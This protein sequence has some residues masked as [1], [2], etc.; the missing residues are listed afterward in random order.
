M[1]DDRRELR[2]QPKQQA[3]WHEIE[4]GVSP[5]VGVGGARGGGKSHLIRSINLLRRWKYPGT[6]S[7]IFRRTFPEL[8]RNHVI[9]LFKEFPELRG[10]YNTQTKTLT[11]PNGSTTEFVTAD[12]DG[13][14][15]KLQGA[16][17]ADIFIDEATHMVQEDFEWLRTCLRSDSTSTI[18]PRM[19]VTC[20]PGGVGHAFIKRVFI[21]R[22]YHENERSEDYSFVPV[23][24]QDNVEWARE[25]LAEDGFSAKDYYGWED[26]RRLEYFIS[27]TA[28]GRNLNSLPTKMR[29]AHLYGRWDVFAGQFFDVFDV[30]RHVHGYREMGL[31]TFHPRWIGFDW[32]FDHP[33]SILWLAHNGQRYCVYREL[34]LR[35]TPARQLASMIAASTKGMGETIA[36]VYLSP[37]A[38]ARKQDEHTLALEIGDLLASEGLPRPTRA[39][40]DRIGGWNFIY[41][42]LSTDQLWITPECKDLIETIPRLIRDEDKPEDVLK[43]DGDDSAEALRYGLMSRVRQQGTKDIDRLIREKVTSADPTVAAFQARIAESKL[44]SS[45]QFSKGRRHRQV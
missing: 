29:D 45:L 17:Y 32:G 6:A 7:M 19:V 38:F 15:K 43:Q 2:L 26:G 13:R 3:V 30:E 5:L 37:D 10:L 25:S 27:R 11:F 8:Q 22:K 42:L 35:E 34:V 14:L 1:S 40:T 16:Q 33:S 12:F 21:D 18:R 24:A 44:T 4:R 41:D 31:D 39:T 23:F 9:P 36:D 20:N 28:Y